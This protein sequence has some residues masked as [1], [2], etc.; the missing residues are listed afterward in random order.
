MYFLKNNG[1]FQVLLFNFR[2]RPACLASL[3]S[4][5]RCRPTDCVSDSCVSGT[6]EGYL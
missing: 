5:A 4:L 1:F 6:L 3:A 2:F